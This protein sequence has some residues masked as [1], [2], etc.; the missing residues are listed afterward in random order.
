MLDFAISLDWRGDNPARATKPFRVGGDG[1]HTWDEDELV[2]FFKTHKPGTLAH[3][4]VTLML[5]AGAVQVDAVKL[6]PK[7]IR[8]GKIWYQRQ[9]TQRYGRVLVSVPIHPDLAEVLDELPKDSPFLATQNGTMR[10]AGGL[11]NLMERWAEDAKPPQCS[12]HG[13]RNACACR[14]AESAATTHEIGAVTGHKTLALVQR[15]TEAAGRES[16][17]D[18]TIEKLIARPNGV[19]NLANLPDRFIKTNT[20]PSGE[21]IIYGKW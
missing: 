21:R 13:L 20:T 9:K 2:Q 17:A 4:A 11:G 8:N 18:S 3:T 12:T 1:F 14:L 15:Y 19:R 10:S 7:N 16:M 5:Y 6:G